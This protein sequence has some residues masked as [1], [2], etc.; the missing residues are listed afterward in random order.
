V[1]LVVLVLALA[2]CGS[3]SSSGTGTGGTTSATSTT[4]FAKTK[5]ILHAGLAFGAFH[6]FIWKPYRAGDFR[7]PFSHK[8]TLVEAGL[9]V[10]FV[11]HELV[12]ALHDAQS[13]PTLSKLVSPITALENR[14]HGLDTAVRGGD[15]STLGSDNAAVGQI[16][17]QAGQAGQPIQ[18]QTP[19]TP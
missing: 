18:E 4:A 12:L 19:A 3:G 15:G 5:F 10:L 2:G 14:L 17:Q 9:A 7:H 13:S 6:H 1:P 11:R 8:L 16:E